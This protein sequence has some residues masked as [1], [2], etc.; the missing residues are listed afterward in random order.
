[1][2]KILYNV[3]TFKGLLG[4]AVVYLAETEGGTQFLVH[5]IQVTVAGA[6]VDKW[7]YTARS[8]MQSYL[9]LGEATI[10][11]SIDM[12]KIADAAPSGV[13]DADGFA[14]ISNGATAPRLYTSQ[15]FYSL[16]GEGISDYTGD[17]GTPVT[18]S[19]G[20]TVVINS[21]SKTMSETI[22]EVTA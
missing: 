1:M 4:T 10:S 17:K 11:S 7:Q 14:I 19:N 16:K 18:G 21:T 9:G 3:A 15:A 8:A 6:P 20:Q 5:K 12:S 2:S 22:S 13:L